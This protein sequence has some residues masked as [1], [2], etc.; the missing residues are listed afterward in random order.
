M[1]LVYSSEKKDQ[2]I[3]EEEFP[4][5]NNLY[6]VPIVQSHI[7]AELVRSITFDNR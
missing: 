2:S 5:S 1:F 7:I 4:H 6:Q 3:L